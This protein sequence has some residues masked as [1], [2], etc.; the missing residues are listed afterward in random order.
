MNDDR[1]KTFLKKT[2]DAIAGYYDNPALSFFVE[3]A[4]DIA[5]YK[6]RGQVFV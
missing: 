6:S 4:K 3:S 1:R 5:T 2:F